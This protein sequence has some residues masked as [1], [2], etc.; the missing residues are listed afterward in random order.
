M[1]RFKIVT[2]VPAYNEEKTIREV[3]TSLN[4]YTNVI[5]VDD[6]STDET[7]KI[8]KNCGAIVIR[9]IKNEGYEKSVEKGLF[10][11]IKMNFD[12]ALTFDA[13]GQHHAKD[14]EK[15]LKLIKEGYDLILGNR[16]YVSRISEKIG[17]SI[18]KKKWGIN[19]PF[20]GFKGYNLSKV[21][22]INFFERYKS[23]GTDLALTFINKGF[24]F[25]NVDIQTSKRLDVSKFGNLF[26]GNF[27]IIKSIFLSN[28][29]HRK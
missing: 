19:D 8:A 16:A 18:F 26:S 10:E 24:R 13:D 7:N 6:C 14:I 21:K 2:I 15:F 20:C 23:V 25:V 28:I 11:S 3:V 9:N 29:Y 5:V 4:K 22:N 27:K 1:G 17:K 12:Y